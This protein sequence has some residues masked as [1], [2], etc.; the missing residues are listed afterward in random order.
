MPKPRPRRPCS[1]AARGQARG[2]PPPQGLPAR[3]RSPAQAGARQAAT[4]AGRARVALSIRAG[5]RSATAAPRAARG[6]GRAADPDRAAIDTPAQALPETAP[7]AA[8]PAPLRAAAGPATK[9]AARRVETEAGPPA[10]AEPR[11]QRNLRR[12]RHLRRQHLF[13]PRLGR[14]LFGDRR[15]NLRGQRLLGRRRQRLGI[16][17]L[18]CTSPFYDRNRLLR[19]GI[20]G[21]REF[22]IGLW[23]LRV[24]LRNL[25]IE[26]DR[27]P[28][29][30]SV[31][32]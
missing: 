17:R 20:F 25:R 21:L 18:A 27:G 32:A 15:W 5:A 12:R 22:R 26:P 19:L 2:E 23:Y 24:R 3:W 6:A 10:V 31:D 28:D 29:T 9:D 1:A 16:R 14:W 30:D 13:G 4:T 8:A 7:A 11:G